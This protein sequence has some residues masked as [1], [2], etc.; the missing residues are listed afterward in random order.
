MAPGAPRLRRQSEAA[1]EI[2]PE[3]RI[4]GEASGEPASTLAS[5]AIPASSGAGDASSWPASTPASVSMPASPL[6]TGRASIQG[7]ST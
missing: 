6:L 7:G 2:V 5:D 1:S 3:S 4:A